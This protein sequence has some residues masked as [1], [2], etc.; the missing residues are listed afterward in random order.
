MVNRSTLSTLGELVVVE[1][2]PRS[3]FRSMVT[4][5]YYGF[6]AGAQVGEGGVQFRRCYFVASVKYRRTPAASS[7]PLISEQ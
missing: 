7:L 4:G 3:K 5:D 6:G 1:G 2:L